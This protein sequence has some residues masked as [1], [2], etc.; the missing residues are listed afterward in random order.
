V[1]VFILNAGRCG[2]TSFIKACEHINNFSCAHESR[3][4]L[5]G[6]LRLDYPDHHIEADNRLSWLL[7]R[8]DKR[9]GDNA[10]YVHL[11]RDRKASVTSFVKRAHFGIMKAY[12]EGQLMGGQGQSPE[13]IAEDYL[14]TIE[15][16]ITL[17]LKDKPNKSLFRLEQSTQD[18]QLFWHRIGAQGDLQMALAEWQILHNASE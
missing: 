1:N 6:R 4:S 11:T 10:Y 8:L 14:E 12:R 16:N 17:F 2:S 3:A 5:T 15:T 7:G 13:E 9:Y 18:F